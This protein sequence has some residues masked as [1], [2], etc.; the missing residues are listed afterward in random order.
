MSHYVDVVRPLALVVEGP[1][2]AAMQVQVL[3]LKP[4]IL[5]LIYLVLASPEDAARRLLDRHRLSIYTVRHHAATLRLVVTSGRS[6]LH[7]ISLIRRHA[8]MVSILPS[9]A[10]RIMR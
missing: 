9:M 1:D 3:R 7:S 2:Y 10:L 4:D 5:L 8:D 6:S